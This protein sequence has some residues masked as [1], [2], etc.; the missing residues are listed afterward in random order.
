MRRW[1]ARLLHAISLLLCVLMLLLWVRSYYRSDTL[2]WAGRFLETGEASKL[3]IVMI[4]SGQGCLEFAAAQDTYWVASDAV[5]AEPWLYVADNRPQH[6]S[7]T[8][9]KLRSKRAWNNFGVLTGSD[10]GETGTVI[11]AGLSSDSYRTIA[12]GPGWIL[13]LVESF[14]AVWVPHWV[15]VLLFGV[16]PLLRA[17]R[18]VQQHLRK[19]VGFCENCGYDLRA[20]AD[21]CPECGESIAGQESRA[22]SASIS[23]S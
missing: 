6:P 2:R 14:K 19:R 8:Q 4:Y 11:V 3:R 7:E 21:R 10:D 17:C 16:L 9:T 22:N 15:F 12:T 23:A 1:L 18:R 20:S 5:I 13:G